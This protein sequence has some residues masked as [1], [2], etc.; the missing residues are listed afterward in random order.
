MTER[1]R[2][3][4]GGR[5]SRRPDMISGEQKKVL[6]LIFSII[7]TAWDKKFFAIEMKGKVLSLSKFSR[8]LVMFK[9]VKIRHQN[10]HISYINIMKGKFFLQKQIGVVHVPSFHLSA[11]LFSFINRYQ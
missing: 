6:F 7:K 11:R 5:E 8:Y 10:G 4:E 3:R 2:E 9:T 1:E